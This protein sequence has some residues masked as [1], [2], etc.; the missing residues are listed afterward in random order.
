M[1]RSFRTGAVKTFGGVT[2]AKSKPPPPTDRDGSAGEVALPLL[3]CSRSIDINSPRDTPVKGLR[4]RRPCAAPTCPASACASATAREA[5]P[6]ILRR[7]GRGA[8]RD[9][10]SGQRPPA[11]R[12]RNPNLRS[13]PAL[14]VARRWPVLVVIVDPR[15]AILRRRFD[16]EV[17]RR[18]AGRT[19]LQRVMAFFAEARRSRASRCDGC[20]VHDAARGVQALLAR[21]PRQLHD[22]N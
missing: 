9:A 18:S 3:V 15:S 8:Q 14:P 22:H 12:F 21:E 10:A 20:C 7:H 17:C 2:R 4:N 6:S 11:V 19:R 5:E 1:Q 13:S 16:V